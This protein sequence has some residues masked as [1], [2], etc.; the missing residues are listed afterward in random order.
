MELHITHE[1]VGDYGMVSEAGGQ[2]WIGKYLIIRSPLI[3][4]FNNWVDT[5]SSLETRSRV[6][7]NFFC[8]EVSYN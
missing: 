5:F 7:Y 2:T 4:V 8:G 6:S 1:L 3:I